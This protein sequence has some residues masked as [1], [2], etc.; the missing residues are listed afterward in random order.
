MSLTLESVASTTSAC[1]DCQ[2][3][4]VDPYQ[5]RYR[6]PFTTCASCEPR[7][8]RAASPFAAFEP[9]PACV[10]ERNDP[11]SRY[12]EAELIAC[13]ACGP[14]AWLERTD[15][16]AFSVERYSMMD[17]VDAVGSLVTMGERVALQWGEGFDVCCDA[18]QQAP[19]SELRE[20]YRQLAPEGRIFRWREDEPRPSTLHRLALHRVKHPVAYVRVATLSEA[21]GLADWILR[22]DLP[23]TQSHD[24]GLKP[25]PLLDVDGS[26]PGASLYAQLRAEQSWS[27]LRLNFGG[28]PLLEDLRS[29][30]PEL[31]P[32]LSVRPSTTSF[33]RFADAAAFLI[34]AD[35]SRAHELAAG[36]DGIGALEALVDDAAIAGAR[37]EEHYPIALP[38]LV[39]TGLP[40]LEPLGMW[41]AMLGDRFAEVA[42]RTMAA[43][44]YVAVADGLARLVHLR[45]THPDAVLSAGDGIDS[46]RLRS[47]TRE[48]LDALGPN[49]NQSRS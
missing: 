33:A 37:R 13:H 6:Y 7:T 12:Y 42:P 27:E 48:A 21:R 45:E 31:E 24:S 3:E 9:C 4:V 47:L 34:E 16:R 29:R 28:L 39:E 41:R 15:G 46:D 23:T 20:A 10:A 32:L 18:R 38:R 14:R 43:R 8:S 17:A 40:Y 30:A 19:L 1:P 5:R 44:W 26:D 35:R 49:A 2:A 11:S 36:V 25:V 22:N